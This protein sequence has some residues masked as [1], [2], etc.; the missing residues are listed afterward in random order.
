MNTRYYASEAM[1]VCDI[2]N[3][4]LDKRV[5]AYA[6]ILKA[7]DLVTLFNSLELSE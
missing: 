3:V 6:L 2:L 1:L 7:S 4:C 5:T